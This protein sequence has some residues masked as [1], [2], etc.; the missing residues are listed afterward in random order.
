MFKQLSL[1]AG[2]HATRDLATTVQPNSGVLDPLRST[3]PQ[4]GD[5]DGM[6]HPNDVNASLKATK[7]P[8]LGIIGLPI[9]LAGAVLFMSGCSDQTSET[10]T[11]KTEA[12]KTQKTAK[13]AMVFPNFGFAIETDGFTVVY[14]DMT[15]HGMDMLNMIMTLQVPPAG[16]V[17]PVVTVNVVADTFPT[18]MP[19]KDMMPTIKVALQETGQWHRFTSER[20]DANSA[21]FEYAMLLNNKKARAYSKVVRG[22]QKLYILNAFAAEIQWDTVSKRLKSAVNSFSTTGHH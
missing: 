11:H 20:S 14:D 22:N 15:E 8:T 9:L 3:L 17:I 19:M 7:P 2:F 21:T 12:A 18:D 6:F 16:E 1:S 4:F 13:G 5:V 10:Q